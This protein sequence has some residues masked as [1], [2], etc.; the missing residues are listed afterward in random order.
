ME[1]PSSS[2]RAVARWI[3]RG[4]AADFVLL[5][6]VFFLHHLD[7]WYLRPDSFP[8]AHVTGL[9]LLHF[10]LLAGLVAGFR[11][12]MAGGLLTVACGAAFFGLI[13]AWNIWHLWVPTL[14]PGL[15]WLGLGLQK[16]RP[17]TGASGP[18]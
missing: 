2:S 16:T 9:M 1:P 18:N 14:V 17:V 6:G 7:E 12:E 5:W 15:I 13:G 3:A 11:W 4:L 8:P 10:G